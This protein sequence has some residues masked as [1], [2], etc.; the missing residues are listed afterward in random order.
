MLTYKLGCENKY[1][2]IC[3]FGGSF[4]PPTIAHK[5]L[6]IKAAEKLNLDKVFFVPVGDG[7]KKD[8]LIDEK[9][10]FKMLQLIC[11]SNEKLDVCD[12][13]INKNYNFKAIDVFKLIDDIYKEDEKYFIMGADN[14]VNILN[15]KNATELVSNY[16]F[17][18]LNRNEINLKETIKENET[19]NKNRLNFY[20]MDNMNDIKISSTCIRNAIK[21]EKV[22]DVK[23]M[24]DKNV[25]EYINEYNLYRN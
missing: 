14:F 8:G 3:I 1:E 15:W 18:L 20:Y 7:Y 17:I 12:I 6:A 21:D 25:L 11:N 22:H 24:V 23:G 13:E 19:L 2:K 10:R 5:T 9:H 16:K 4:N